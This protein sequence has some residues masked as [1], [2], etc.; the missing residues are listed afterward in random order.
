MGN[1]D[2]GRF[3]DILKLLDEGK[4]SLLNSPPLAEQ[5]VPRAEKDEPS[6][7]IDSQFSMFSKSSMDLVVECWTTYIAQFSNK[8]D[9]EIRNALEVEISRDLNHMQIQPVIRRSYRRFVVIKGL[10]ES[11][12]SWD[13][14]G[15]SLPSD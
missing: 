3:G 11:H 5:A 10:Q 6:K 2:P 4:L 9:A 8:S 14:D 12:I 13:R 15:V 1:S 7:W